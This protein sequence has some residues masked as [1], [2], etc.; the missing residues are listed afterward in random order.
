MGLGNLLFH[1][2]ARRSSLGASHHP[3]ATEA[4]FHYP[5]REQPLLSKNTSRPLFQPPLGCTRTSPINRIGSCAA[6]IAPRA[7]SAARPEAKGWPRTTGLS[8]LEGNQERLVSTA[9]RRVVTTRSS[10][11]RS[12]DGFTVRIPSAVRRSCSWTG[13]APPWGS[14][15]IPQ[16]V[17]RV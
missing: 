3:P 15:L 9:Q 8:S 1:R 5:S 11:S 6:W 13:G 12:A 17:R 7:E 10:P 14:R 2:A 4:L 16:V